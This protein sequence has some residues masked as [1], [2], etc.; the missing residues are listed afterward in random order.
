[1]KVP[2]RKFLTTGAGGILLLAS[3]GCD[4]I[5]LPLRQ[6]LASDD[7]SGPF[8]QPSSADVDPITHALNRAG[9]GP[10]PGDYQR[11]AKLAKNPDAAAAAWIEKQL[12]PEDIPDEEAEY[13]ARRFETL[14]EPL[15][16]LFEYQPDLLH[17]ELMR[18]T[19]TR[20]VHSER[21]FFEVMVQFWSD[22][23]N[24]DPSKG[25]CKWLKVY[26]DREVI[27]KHALGR[28]S[29]LLA[30]SATSP[31]MLWYLDGRVN[32]R[33]SPTDKPN[34]NYARELLELHTLGV[35]GG[36]TQRDVM[37]V[38]RCLTGW[39]VRSTQTKPYLELGKVEF[40]PA[41]HDFGA[42]TVLGQT[43][44]ATETDLPKEVLEQRGRHE[45]ERVLR[46]VI[47]HPSTA[48]HLAAKL[49]RHFIAD[50][51]PPAAVDTVAAAF[52]NSQGDIRTT[53]RALVQTEEFRSS[54][55]NK[56]KRP[57]TFVVSALRATGAK[58]DCSLEVVDYLK[59]MGHA[60]FNY[61]TPEGYPD[62]ATPWMGTL[63]WR[64]NFAAALSQNKIK[65]TRTDEESLLK[66]TGGSE[67]LMAHLLGR[68]PSIPEAQAFKD[69]GA[70][71]SLLLASPGFQYC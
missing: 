63:L 19:L 45:L 40:D 46:I 65:G 49:C 61:P 13:A 3:S 50:T 71:V 52:Q 26:D 42:K 9:F 18:A 70:G 6:L 17:N 23:F 48:R 5:P 35:H 64:W 58:T 41:L 7:A 1:M 60:P 47:D 56:F 28:F 37:E 27:R 69:S 10:R 8:Q 24:I 44:P 21:Q 22:H 68:K 43:L 4:Q 30:A 12:H 11:V 16:E 2:R 53:L 57:F 14:E 39:T 15:G 34:E 66:E 31:A 25:D 51:P 62:Q 67:A 55:K 38:A 59:R 29:D 36:Y 33:S 32:R 54:R 20:A